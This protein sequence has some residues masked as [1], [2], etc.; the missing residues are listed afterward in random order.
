MVLRLTSR[1]PRRSGF[2][3]PSSALLLADLTPASGRQN[4]T[5]SPSASA[6]F[7]TRTARV[8]RIPPHVGN[9]RNAPQMGRD[10]I[11]IVLILPPPSS[12]NSE[13]PNLVGP[14]VRDDA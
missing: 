7:V 14:V 13:N 3:S 11:A 4:H 2:L 12:K 1:S 9:V 6:P 10:Q 8:H 5:T